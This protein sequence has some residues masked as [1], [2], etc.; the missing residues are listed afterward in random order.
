MFVDNPVLMILDNDTVDLEG[1]Q[2]SSTSSSAA[3]LSASLA[4]AKPSCR[5]IRWSSIG[6]LVHGLPQGQPDLR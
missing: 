1:F 3:V 2:P 5:R 6:D 4:R